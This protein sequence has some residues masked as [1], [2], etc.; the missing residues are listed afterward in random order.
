MNKDFLNFFLILINIFNYFEFQINLCT[1]PVDSLIRAV[2]GRLVG[3]V[4]AQFKEFIFFI[5][6]VELKS[7][8]LYL[9]TN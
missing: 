6:T 5:L 2:L 8:Y 3:I 9:F 4:M 1:V 7:T